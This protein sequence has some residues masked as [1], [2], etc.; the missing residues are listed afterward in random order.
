M[1][2]FQNLM[3]TYE[4]PITINNYPYNFNTRID[5]LSHMGQ[6]IPSQSNIGHPVFQL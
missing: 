2:N 6:H 1:M 5:F 4:Y 3:K